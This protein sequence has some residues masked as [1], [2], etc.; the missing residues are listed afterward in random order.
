MQT[1][2]PETLPYA[3]I[4]DDFDVQRAYLHGDCWV[5]AL[6]LCERLELDALVLCDQDGDPV[7]CFASFEAPDEN[8]RPFGEEGFG[9]D[10]RGWRLV[11]EI[12]EEFFEDGLDHDYTFDRLTI[13]ELR[14]RVERGIDGANITTLP[15]AAEL[16]EHWLAA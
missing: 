11:S 7:H 12:V 5:L 8:A 14:R 10:I 16:V 3:A 2:T 6:A 1:I 13:D 15:P 4:S 9:I